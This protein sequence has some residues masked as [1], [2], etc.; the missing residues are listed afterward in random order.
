MASRAV[1]CNFKETNNE[2]EYEALIPGLTL[3]HQ[4]G[5]KN[6]P[7]FGD[8]QLIINQVQGVYQAKDDIMIQY[9]AVA[10]DSS[11]N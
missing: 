3:A 10:S 7:V 5:A 6:I 1:R 8:S 11:K 4:M 2:R 9:L